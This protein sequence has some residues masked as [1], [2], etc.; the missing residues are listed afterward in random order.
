MGCVWII[1]HD[2][3][4]RVE[5][6]RR[7]ARPPHSLSVQSFRCA[8]DA[9]RAARRDDPPDGMILANRLP[10]E[11]GLALLERRA[12][13]FR[14]THVFVVTRDA[15][16]DTSFHA[17][18][19][20]AVLLVKPLPRAFYSGFVD[21]VRSRASNRVRGGLPDLHAASVARCAAKWGLSMRQTEVLAVF[22]R[23]CRAKDVAVQLE[24]S[25]ETVKKHVRETLRR[26]KFEDMRA[27]LREVWLP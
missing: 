20:G 27:L 2:P 3:G 8:E 25:P 19:L 24:M 17:Y 10:A 1:E 9:E 7:L 14:E 18:R 23:G 12:T 16:A 26:S 6:E 5:Y 11:S 15:D 4:P 13:F 22:A 21:R